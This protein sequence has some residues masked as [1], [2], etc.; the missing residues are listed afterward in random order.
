MSR[1]RPRN[2]SLESCKADALNFMSISEWRRNSSKA[3]V[4]SYRYGWNEEC[5]AHMVKNRKPRGYWTLQRCAAEAKTFKTKQSW[6][7]G[8]SSSYVTAK[9]R[10]WLNI[11]SEHMP[12]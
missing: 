8:S 11:C 1:G 6:R 9:S 4:A 5:T 2:W 3:Y 12:Y 7:I 10:G